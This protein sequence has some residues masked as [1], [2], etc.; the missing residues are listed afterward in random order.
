MTFLG[1]ANSALKRRII[2]PSFRLMILVLLLI[3]FTGKNQ[4]IS[5][6]DKPKVKRGFNQN[7]SMMP[8]LTPKM[9]ENIALLKPEILRYPGGTVTH[10]WNWKEGVIESRKSKSKHLIGEIKKLS[11]KTN[12]QFV[13]VLDILNKTIDDQIE[14]L[15]SIQ[16]T[17]VEIK[18]IELGNELY[19]KEK[20]YEKVFP[21][22]KEYALKVN[23]WIPALRDKFPD[24]KIAA[25]L[26]GRSVKKSNAKMFYWNKYVVESSIKNVDAFTYHFYINENAS[27]EKEKAEFI[28]V[29][30]MANTGEKELWITEYG[31]KQ[32]KTDERYFTELNALADFI[33]NYPN[34]TI[35]LN[36]QIIGGTKNKLSEDGSKLTEEGNLF[37]KRVK[38]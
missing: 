36:H 13:F 18:Y 20:A 21:T 11:T 17:G 35:A 24:A 6:C 2:Q 19:A 31:N 34:V 15:T 4:N 9:I 29:T 33:E 30:K 25:L 27:F 12:A 32:E 28:A 37:L 16:K 22:G 8:D 38:K 26:L 7:F 14:M 10:S 5:N 23:Q 1:I 3:S